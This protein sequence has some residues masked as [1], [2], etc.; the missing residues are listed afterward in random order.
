MGTGIRHLKAV[1]ARKNPFEPEATTALFHHTRGI[2]RLVQNVALAAVALGLGSCQI[3]AL[4]DDEVNALLGVD[5]EAESV[6]YMT[7]VGRPG[8][9]FGSDTNH[10]AI[11]G[12]ELHDAVEKVVDG[13][14]AAGGEVRGSSLLFKSGSSV[15]IEMQTST[16]LC[17]ASSLSKSMSRVTNWFL[18]TIPTG[19]RNSASTCKQPRVSLSRRS[20]G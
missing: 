16:A 11:L 15:V 7:A 2:P 6:L 13:P 17:A 18:V 3:A 8:T 10:A 19:F 5:G 14:V 12:A 9:G 20:T 1:G 4:F